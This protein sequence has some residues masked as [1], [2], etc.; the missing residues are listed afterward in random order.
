MNFNIVKTTRNKQQT[1]LTTLSERS[2]IS[3]S[4][5]RSIEAGVG[6]TSTLKAIM[7][8]LGLGIRWSPCL[9][10]E[11]L[12]DYIKRM[13][14]LKE[15]SQRGLAKEIGISH[16]TIWKIEHG[17][18]CQLDILDK[19]DKALSLKL[20]IKTSQHNS[21]EFY[22]PKSLMQQLYKV[23]PDGFDLDPCSPTSDGSNTNIKATKYLTATDDGLSKSWSKYRTIY[24]N[25]P[26][27]NH[28]IWLKKTRQEIAT[29]DQE[30]II[31][32]LI[33]V[34][35]WYPYWHDDIFPIAK[36]IVFLRDRVVFVEPSGKRKHQN[37]ASALIV[38]ATDSD[39]CLE[40]LEQIRAEFTEHS[41]VSAVY[42][43]ST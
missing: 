25:P 10:D 19:V 15:F 29:T 30:Q 1:T 20:Q 43:T 7:E 33:P 9:G 35:L 32:M 28:K 5:I 4:A 39:W 16:P 41:F 3:I 17:H 2:G 14:I 36:R 26:F 12:G 22:T 42:N 18:D 23:F 37:H 6:T 31:I 24:C 40:K 27:D 8:K 13:R 21:S 34:F 11:S 38:Y